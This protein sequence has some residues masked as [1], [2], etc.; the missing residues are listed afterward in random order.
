MSQFPNTDGSADGSADDL[1][2]QLQSLKPRSTVDRDQLLSRLPADE[3]ESPRIAEPQSAR[4]RHVKWWP[5]LTALSWLV[6]AGV[7]WSSTQTTA[8][9]GSEAAGVMAAVSNDDTSPAAVLVGT[10]GMNQLG[11]SLDA[12]EHRTAVE[13]P[14]LVESQGDSA[15]PYWLTMLGIDVDRFSPSSAEQRWERMQEEADAPRQLTASQSTSGP[16]PSATYASLRNE[17]DAPIR[18]NWLQQ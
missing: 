12:I 8:S 7:W 3:S 4:S 14:A 15:S 6:T 1:K 2:Q 9:R 10:S 18:R 13:S 16:T 5:M 11:E 17:F